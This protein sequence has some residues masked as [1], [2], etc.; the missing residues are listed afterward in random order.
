MKSVPARQ[1]LNNGIKQLGTQLRLARHIKRMLDFIR[2]QTELCAAL[3]EPATRAQEASLLDAA[4]SVRLRQ[5]SLSN[6]PDTL[7]PAADQLW[8]SCAS[9]CTTH[10]TNS[11]CT[12]RII[13]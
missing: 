2:D 8:D 3:D 9:Y 4:A 10:I 6:V 5:H 12:W 1:H 11:G 7:T 13:E